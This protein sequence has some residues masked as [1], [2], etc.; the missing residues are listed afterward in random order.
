MDPYYLYIKHLS[1]AEITVELP[2]G[3]PHLSF[4]TFPKFRKI[5]L[6]S[7]GCAEHEGLIPDLSEF[8][9]K[10]WREQRIVTKH[11]VGPDYNFTMVRY[12]M[13]KCI[14]I[15]Q[16]MEAQQLVHKLIVSNYQLLAYWVED[17]VAFLT[18]NP[19]IAE[20]LKQFLYKAKAGR[21]KINH[22][23]DCLELY[24]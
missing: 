18:T 15:D 7:A 12:N 23:G 19:K 14:S 16:N 3:E 24:I 2:S 8:T 1:K 4:E 17:S 11:Y 6:H 9:P 10:Q 5:K 21:G 13:P 22:A 20:G